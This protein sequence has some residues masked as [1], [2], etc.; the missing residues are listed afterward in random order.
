MGPKQSGVGRVDRH[1]SQQAMTVDQD[2]A[3][4]V[5]TWQAQSAGQ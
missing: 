4:L 2:A 3:L 1:R 5:R